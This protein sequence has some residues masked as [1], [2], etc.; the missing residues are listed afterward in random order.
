MHKYQ[1][2]RIRNRTGIPLAGTVKGQHRLPVS[3]FWCRL[4]GVFPVP[5]KPVLSLDLLPSYHYFCQFVCKLHKLSH[6]EPNSII[7]NAVWFALKKIKSLIF[8]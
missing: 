5:L 2:N 3:Q 7:L 6:E 8:L 4:N 1:K